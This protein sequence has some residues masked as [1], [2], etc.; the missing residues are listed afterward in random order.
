MRSFFDEKWS[1]TI[2]WVR[3]A[4]HFFI[5]PLFFVS[6]FNLPVGDRR[7]SFAL[8]ERRGS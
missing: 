4:N 7:R 2:G 5:Y 1:F 6:I 8:L 3:S